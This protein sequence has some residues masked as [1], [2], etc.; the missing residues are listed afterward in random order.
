MAVRWD[1]VKDDKD[2][3]WRRGQAVRV[4]YTLIFD[5]DRSPIHRGE[6]W[7]ARSASEAYTIAIDLDWVRAFLDASVFVA[8][9]L[10]PAPGTFLYARFLLQGHENVVQQVIDECSAPE[11]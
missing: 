4:G 5:D 10:D 8:Q 9:V 11:R 6:F 3:R 1:D 7:Y 2:L